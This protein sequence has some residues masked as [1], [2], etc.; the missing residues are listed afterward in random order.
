[1]TSPPTQ[2]YLYKNTDARDALSEVLPY[3]S[4]NNKL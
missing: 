3:I 4:T 1:M 2:A